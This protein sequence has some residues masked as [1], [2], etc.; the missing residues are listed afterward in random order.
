MKPANL[1]QLTDEETGAL[2]EAL[3]DEYK[4]ISTYEQ[5]IADFGPVRPFSN[6]I[7]AERRHVEALRSLYERYDVT[8]PANPWQGKVP[9]Y[10]SLHHACLAGVTA[11]IDNATMYDRLLTMTNRSDII[12]VFQNLR[13]ASQDNHLRAFQRCAER[14]SGGE[15]ARSGSDDDGPG[16]GRQRRRQ[17][18][19]D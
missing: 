12:G 4:A 1:N 7:D 3:D 19:G 10:E 8:M 13:R 5:V 9:T 11:E 15:A 17:A 2:H 18:R 6:I 16:G 14:T